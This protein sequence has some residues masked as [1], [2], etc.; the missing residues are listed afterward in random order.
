MRSTSILLAGLWLASMAGPALSS[1]RIAE[2]TGVDGLYGELRWRA[3]HVSQDGFDNDAYA[4]PLRL[5]AGF[6][7]GALHGLSFRVEY[8]YV[9]DLGVEDY[10][11]G[12]G[13]TPDR[14]G[15][16]VI[17]DPP[18]GDLNQAY[19]QW[20]SAQGKTLRAGRQRIIY[21]N[22][23]FIGN[24][25]WRQNE[26]TYDAATLAFPG[27]GNFGVRAGWLG[28]VHRIFGD[29]V[30][31]G[32][33]DMNT[34]IANLD[35]TFKGFGKLVGY[36]Y[37]IDNDD[38]AAFSTSTYGAS[39]QSDKIAWA[40][41]V[42]FDYRVEYAHQADAANA[43][44]AFSADYF[45]VD[46]ALSLAVPTINVGYESLGGDQERAGA[47]FRT[48]LAT[49]HAFNGWADMF[50]TTPDA[51][52]TDLY[53]GVKWPVGPWTLNVIGHVFQAQSGGKDLGLE[54]D[55]SLSRSLADDVD[56]LIKAARFDGDHP[57]YA[58]TTKWWVQL[59]AGF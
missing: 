37:D 57:A 27:N 48:P 19:V 34:W 53:G 13:N 1:D 41:D 38:V 7:S 21:D 5:R 2:L 22:A 52:L 40:N 8:D 47:A 43:P 30:P 56:L 51:G 46:L 14:A 55:T 29:D 39:W 20:V 3:E 12:G 58:D 44:V 45:R 23:R 25:G 36:V 31:A 11:A 6:A 54:L 32:E 10:N 24:V 17:A 35:Y 59:R 4:L 49:L 26:Q 9:F 18:G 33:N 42:H 50:L 28:A 16:P 15:Y